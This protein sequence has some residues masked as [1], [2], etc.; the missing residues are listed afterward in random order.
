MEKYQV[1]V[2]SDTDSSE[3]NESVI[4]GPT[5]EKEANAFVLGVEYAND[6]ALIVKVQ[7]VGGVK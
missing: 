4:Y 7:L 1:V 5:S 2:E 3:D 6:S